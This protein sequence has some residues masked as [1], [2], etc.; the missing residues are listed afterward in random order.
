MDEVKRQEYSV[1][2]DGEKLDAVT[3][4]LGAGPKKVSVNYVRGKETFKY[5]FV[6]GGY[7]PL[8]KGIEDD[9]HLEG[10]KRLVPKLADKLREAR[11]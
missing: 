5:I 7:M 9:E 1:E 2:G 6:N 11:G 4:D 8:E 10:L 3:I